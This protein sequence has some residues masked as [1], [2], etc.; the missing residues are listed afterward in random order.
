MSKREITICDVCENEIID[1]V[2]SVIVDGEKYSV[3]GIIVSYKNRSCDVCKE[4]AKAGVIPVIENSRF[5]M[6]KR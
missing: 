6:K 1:K 4:C 2:P 5:Q 3:D